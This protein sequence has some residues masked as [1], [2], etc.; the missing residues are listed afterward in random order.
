MDPEERVFG[1]WKRFDLEMDDSGMKVITSGPSH[2][3]SS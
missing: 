1:E 2:L 3:A